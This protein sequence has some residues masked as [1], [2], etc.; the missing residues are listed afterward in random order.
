MISRYILRS[1]KRYRLFHSNGTK[2]TKFT[3]LVGVTGTVTLTAGL[4]PI[5]PV[6]PDQ[7]PIDLPVLSVDVGG[8]QRTP[9]EKKK[10]PSQRENGAL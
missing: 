1:N 2:V 9:M 3:L 6:G 5:Y 10:A 8:N 7:L 4:L